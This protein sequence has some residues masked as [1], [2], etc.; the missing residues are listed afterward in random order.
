MP[1]MPRLPRPNFDLST[2]WICGSVRTEPLT[3]W[4]S[5]TM[6]SPPEKCHVKWLNAC[7][8]SESADTNPAL[9]VYFSYCP[10]MKGSTVQN[11]K[12]GRSAMRIAWACTNWSGMS[13]SLRENCRAKY[14]ATACMRTSERTTSSELTAGSRRLGTFTTSFMSSAP[15]MTAGKAKRMAPSLNG[16]GQS[17]TDRTILASR[18]SLLSRCSAKLVS[19]TGCMGQRSDS[20]QSRGWSSKVCSSARQRA[21]P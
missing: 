11:S 14:C 7:A 13:G 2:E 3:P 10:G 18:G 21:G 4:M 9:L 20:A 8:T 16:H 19:N 5:V 12:S 6:T 15:I 1:S 17:R